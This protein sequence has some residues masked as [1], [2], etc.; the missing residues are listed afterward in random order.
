MLKKT[1]ALTHISVRGARTHNL[2]NID[3][4]IPHNELIVITG[5]SGSGKSSLAFDTIYAEGQRRYVESLSSYA[6]QFLSLMEKPDIDHIEGLSPSIAIDQKSA[7]HNPRSTVGTTTEI[8]DYLRLL[9]ARVGVPHCPYHNIAL[10]AQTISQMIE[11][12]MKIPDE[13]KIMVLSP[14]VRERKGEHIQLLEGLLTQGFLRAKINGEVVMLENKPKLNPKKKHTIEIVVD[15]LVKRENIENRL[16]ESLETALRLCNGLAKIS[17]VDAASEINLIFSENHSCL[18][19]GFSIHDLEPKLFSFNNPIGACSLCDGIGTVEYFDPKLVVS[20]PEE[21]IAN[22]ALIGGWDK[23][24]K[25]YFD[26]LLHVADYYAFDIYQPFNKLAEEHQKI[27]LYGSGR[28]KLLL[29]GGRYAKIRRF[30]GVI[31][32]LERRYIE[33]QV[34]EVRETLNQYRIIDNCQSC[35]GSRLNKTANNVLIN[36]HSLSAITS[37]PIDKTLKYFNT[38]KL[39]KK[40]TQIAE[41]I[42]RE[43]TLRLTFLVNVGLNYLTLSRSAST[44]SGGEAQRI[45]LASQIGAGLVG[46]MY[47]LD[48]PSIG[49]HQRD[50]KKLLQTLFHLRDIGN[51]VIVVEHDE[52]TIRNADTIIDIGPKAGIHGGEVI[53][54]GNLQQ[55]IQEKKSITGQFLSN[56]NSIEIPS[57]RVKAKPNYH[58]KIINARANNLNNVSVTIP[59]GVLTCITGVSGSGKS[60]LM[61]QTLYPVAAKMLNRASTYA[62]LHDSIEGLEFLNKVV[63]INQ[64]PIGRTPRSNPATYV[65][66]F[67]SI[68][69]LFSNTKEARARGYKPGRFSFNVKGGRCEACQGD[70]LIRVAMHFLAD[71]YVK[72]DQ[73]HGKRYNPDTLSI[74]Y[75]QKNIADILNMTIEEASLFFESIPAINRK[76]QTLN[77]VGLSYIKLGQSAT[78][79]SGGEAQRIKLAKELARR[80]TGRTLYIM[81]EPTTGLHFYDTKLLLSIISHLRNKGN[82]VIIIEHNLDIIKSADWIIDLGPEGGADG[83]RIIA[84]GTPEQICKVKKSYTGQFLKPILTP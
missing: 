61:N 70:G 77:D 42:I 20:N 83:G 15:R 17:G 29:P 24:S 51:T 5:I 80:D 74:T 14:I 55:I 40:N 41:K 84:E 76:L 13:T 1:S 81:D 48:E 75:K 82:T 79:L 10:H 36:T 38:L 37:L 68:R 53:A 18:H 12:V 67:T 32:N 16:A 73:C 39:D 4:D 49:L 78:T 23:R 71:I 19:C 26:M 28:E 3:I 11:H 60:T 54:Q 2:K 43:I 72:C 44:L 27:I 62:S 57:K 58:L 66:L 35:G 47:V 56:E 63:N 59:L 52:E 45:R 65:D 21:N 31:P 7:S 9:F 8:Y 50:N 69:E 25:H 34:K 46:V 64:S 30:E 22:G 6:R 33:T